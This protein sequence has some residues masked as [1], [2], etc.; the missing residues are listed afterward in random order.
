M[1]GGGPLRNSKKAIN[2]VLRKPKHIKNKFAS[3]KNKFVCFQWTN[4][5]PKIVY[6]INQKEFNFNCLEEC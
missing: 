4:L 1:F 3:R 5:K 2:S 6:C